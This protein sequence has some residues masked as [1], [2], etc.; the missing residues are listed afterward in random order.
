MVTWV[1]F[2][3]LQE[4][5]YEEVST[6]RMAD[7]VTKHE[8]KFGCFLCNHRY[9]SKQMLASH[10]KKI[11]DTTLEFRKRG[12]G[13]RECKICGKRLASRGS[14]YNHIKHLHE[15]KPWNYQWKI[16]CSV[17]AI[18]IKEFSSFFFRTYFSSSIFL[19]AFSSSYVCTKRVRVNLFILSV[20]AIF[21]ILWSTV[22]VFKL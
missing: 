21:L 2:L 1:F 3:S 17:L 14:L 12:V 19:L 5:D 6:Q 20:F 15:G 9:T 16:I 7:F 8:R 13:P 10:M 18:F 22:N 11:H 4:E